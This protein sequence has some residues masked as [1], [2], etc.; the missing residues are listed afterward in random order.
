MP[1]RNAPNIT[2]KSFTF[3]SIWYIIWSYPHFIDFYIN[4][5]LIKIFCSYLL[6]KALLASALGFSSSITV[7]NPFLFTLYLLFYLHFVLNVSSCLDSL[8]KKLTFFLSLFISSSILVFHLCVHFSSYALLSSIMSVLL[9][10][11]FQP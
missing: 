4:L 6:T 5:C 1:F 10:T 3:L 9:P 8:S 7:F 11:Y 2:S